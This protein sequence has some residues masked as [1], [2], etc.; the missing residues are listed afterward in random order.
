[1]SI[2]I[3]EKENWIL[4]KYSGDISH[5][6]LKGVLTDMV[7]S[8][9][10]ASKPGRG[11]HDFRNA[12][13]LD[14]HF[15]HLNSMVLSKKSAQKPLADCRSAFIVDKTY[16]LGIVNQFAVLAE[17]LGLEVRAFVDPDEARSWLM[18]DRLQSAQSARPAG[19]LD[20]FDR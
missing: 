12:G 5:D 8:E 3:V 4:F 20:D 14:L 7:E 1:M 18:Q 16:M 2:E 9:K 13:C 10:L 15:E 11:L 19:T 17:D 6:Q